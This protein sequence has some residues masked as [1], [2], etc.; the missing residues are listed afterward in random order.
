MPCIHLKAVLSL[1]F[2]I[3]HHSSNVTLSTWI[4]ERIEVL[5]KDNKGK[6][7]I[8]RMYGSQKDRNFV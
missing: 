8:L 2:L 4:T 1:Y 7:Q 3:L 5:R 6:I